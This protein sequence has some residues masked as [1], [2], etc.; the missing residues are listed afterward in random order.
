MPAT[1]LL[2]YNINTTL[3]HGH[4]VHCLQRKSSP[5]LKSLRPSATDLWCFCG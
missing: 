3:K 1:A 5:S 2:P 4:W